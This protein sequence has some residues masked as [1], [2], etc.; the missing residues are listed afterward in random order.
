MKVGSV[1]MS[2]E[3]AAVWLVFRF[4]AL[5]PLD[6]ASALGGWLGRTIGV[7]LPVTRQARRNLRRIFPDW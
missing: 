1:L 5:L 2:L 3:A 6:T 4:F 7:R